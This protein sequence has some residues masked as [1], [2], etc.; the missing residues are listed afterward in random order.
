MIYHLWISLNE[1]DEGSVT[2]LLQNFQ[3]VQ[4][5]FKS[6]PNVSNSLI[7]LGSK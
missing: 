5:F 4:K 1:N 2:E 7:K 3:I 6:L